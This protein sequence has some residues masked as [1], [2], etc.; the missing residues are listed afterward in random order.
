MYYH[1]DGPSI[2]AA[3]KLVNLGFTM[4]YR[5]EGKYQAWIDAGYPI[6]Y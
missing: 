6:E 5:L 4:V 3:N 1:A 2:S